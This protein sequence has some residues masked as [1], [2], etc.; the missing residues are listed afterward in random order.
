MKISI[1]MISFHFLLNFWL[2]FLQSKDFI[3][4]FL[5]RIQKIFSFLLKRSIFIISSPEFVDSFFYLL[6]QVGK[7][8]NK[9]ILFSPLFAHFKENA[10]HF[11]FCVYN[12][13]P[14]LNFS[15]FKLSLK[16][17][18]CLIFFFSCFVHLLLRLNLSFFKLGLQVCNCLIFIV[19]F[20]YYQ[21]PHL[22][23]N[24]I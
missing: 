5:Q 11:V 18:N 15:F 9:R 6:A 14:R 4:I 3:I 1:C 16:V 10:S 2:Y 22:L 12:L 13:L 23:F 8:I 19:K 7:S 20:G 17:R 21:I 24:L